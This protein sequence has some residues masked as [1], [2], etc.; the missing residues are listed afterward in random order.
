M[1]PT[2]A[3]FYVKERR[4][5]PDC[6]K[7]RFAGIAFLR[8]VQQTLVEKF[9]KFQVRLQQYCESREKEVTVLFCHFL[10]AYFYM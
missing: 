3:L 4:F 6:G 8:G 5:G 9:I 2:C 10:F 1:T 7:N